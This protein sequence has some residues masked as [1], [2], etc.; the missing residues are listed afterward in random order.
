MATSK[1]LVIAID[2]DGTIVEQKFPEIGKLL[3]GAV[4]AI[5]QLKEDGHKIIIWSCRSLKEHIDEAKYFLNYYEIPFDAF[6]RSIKGATKIE[7]FPKVYADVYIDDRQLGGLPAWK[8]IYNIIK[9]GQ[10]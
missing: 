2:F 9:N 3:P 1:S 5:R 8:D 7:T 4:K 10:G 6:N